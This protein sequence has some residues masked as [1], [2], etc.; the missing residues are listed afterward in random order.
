MVIPAH[1]ERENLPELV[2]KLLPVLESSTFA[3]EW[4]II[5]VDD[6]STDGTSELAEA[7]SEGHPHVRCVHRKGEPGF[8]L[9]IAEG[10][11][12]AEGAY[13]IPFMA[14]L[15]DDP[16]DLLALAASAEEGHDVVYGSRFIPGGKAIGYPRIKFVANRLYNRLVG[17]LFGLPHR[18]ITNAFKCYRREVLEDIGI[19]TIE[20]EGFEI[21]VELPLRAHIA[22]FS[23]IELPVTWEGRRR[24]ESK[25]RLDSSGPIYLKRL[26]SLFI[27]GNVRALRDLLKETVK[28]P[29]AMLLA[30]VIVGSLVL[31]GIFSYL[32]L[33][34]VLGALG[35]MSI[36]LWLLSCFAIFLSF[37]FRTW[38]WSVLLRSAG[39]VIRRDLVFASLFLGWLVNY[40]IPARIGDLVRPVA[41]S[42]SSRIVKASLAFTTV[43]VERAMDLAALVVLLISS[44]WFLGTIK[45]RGSHILVSAGGI[46]ILIGLLV[47]ISLGSRLAKHLPRFERF[48]GSIDSMA[49]AIR[50]IWLNKPAF[51]LTL[52]LTVPI[53]MTEIA[54]LYFS[55]GALGVNIGITPIILA[56]TTAFLVQTVPITPGGIGIHEAAIVGVLAVYNV[57][58]SDAM[59]AAL[60][61][62]LARAA[63]VYL[64]GF[65][66][67]IHL[68]L[69]SRR[70]MTHRG[71]TG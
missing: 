37:A 60:L 10:F 31:I 54:C 28:I 34:E 55:L 20:S 25:L 51:A 52:G 48:A 36:S 50:S 9:A 42:R 21:T 64:F 29:Y 67:V 23:S 5:L 7:L 12:H 56:A 57:D 38:R 45:W 49:R 47:G 11:R 16:S 30:S 2:S 1:N 32:D 44:S 58:G 68:A 41:I 69:A 66:S 3:N 35:R 63:V 15:S 71:S 65:V 46:L 62:H 8:G 61:D 70:L 39:A 22:G 27:M 17:F 26:A 33:G 53:W 14:D 43:L 4:E 40:I 59:A 19:D 6:N 13:I 18:D 24:G